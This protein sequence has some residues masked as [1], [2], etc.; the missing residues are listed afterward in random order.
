[1][2]FT[3]SLSTTFTARCVAVNPKGLRLE[4]HDGWYNVSRFAVGV[5]LP[6]KG[7]TV[8][9]VLDR[10]GFLRSCTVLDGP[11]AIAGGSDAAPA[12]RPAS[13]RDRTITR[14]AVLKA[15]AEFGA[16]R[17][18][19]KSGDVLAIAD[20]WVAWIERAPEDDLTNGRRLAYC[21]RKSDAERIVR[22]VQAEH[23]AQPTDQPT[24]HQESE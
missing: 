13:D 23:A 22:A 19:L 3:D 11:P 1:M 5:V 14:L 6:E 20:S 4:G 7:D 24:A 8:T 9:I 10:A 21:L 17:P 18:N 12:A 15:A 16:S 2:A